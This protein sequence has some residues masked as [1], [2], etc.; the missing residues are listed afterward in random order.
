MELSTLCQSCMT[1]LEE[2]PGFLEN[3][4]PLYGI[5]ATTLCTK[6]SQ[7]MPSVGEPCF[8]LFAE[9]WPAG[10]NATTLEICGAL[11]FC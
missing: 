1:F 7:H 9:Y 2:L 4:S 11:Y 6:L 10:T 3:Y 5:N 8:K